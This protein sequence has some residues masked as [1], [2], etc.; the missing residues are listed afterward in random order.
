MLIYPL[1]GP[2]SLMK[3]AADPERVV[4]LLSG[5][6][7]S[8]IP[9]SMAAAAPLLETLTPDIIPAA[10]FKDIW[11]VAE[12]LIEGYG[13]GESAGVVRMMT[14]RCVLSQIG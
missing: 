10:V 12:R 3:A 7:M 4:A 8:Q 13:A 14:V 11:S 1:Q 6:L 9:D 5:F 2:F